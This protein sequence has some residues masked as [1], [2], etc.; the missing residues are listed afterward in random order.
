MKAALQSMSQ[1]LFQARAEVDRANRSKAELQG[2]IKS[3]ENERSAL[4]VAVAEI[5][6]LKAKLAKAPSS[7]AAG[8]HKRGSCS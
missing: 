3:L 2:T 4:E 8:R 5:P 7:G 1:D 6:L